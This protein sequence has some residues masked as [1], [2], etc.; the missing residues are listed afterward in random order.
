MHSDG[1][2]DHPKAD[3]P[4]GVVVFLVALPLCLGIAL[5]AGA[6]LISG[7][8]SG[9]IG[10]LVIGYLSNSA[11]SVSGPAASVSAVVLVAIQELGSFE[12]FLVALVL[13]GLIQLSLGLL[14]LGIIAEYIPNSIIKGLLAAIGI[15]LIKSQLLYAVGLDTGDGFSATATG[16]WA[17]LV[18]QL[19][20][21][22]SSITL[23][24]VLLTGFSLFI[25]LFWNKTP[26][27]NF[28]LLPPAL[29]VVILGVLLNLV[30]GW[31][32]PSLY[33]EGIHLV[34]IPSFEGV[35]S[36]VTFPD[37]S[38]MTNGTVWT[39]ALALA[40]IA[41]ISTLLNLEATDNIDP[42]RR[43]SSPNR[44]LIAQGI[45]NTLAGLLGGIAITSVIVR[46]SVNIEA[47]G[48]TKLSTIIHG[49]LLFLSVLFFGDIINLIPLSALA[50]ILLVVGY[51]LASVS[52]FKEFYQKG[53]NQFIPFVVTVVA[54]LFTDVLVGV[55]IGAVTSFFF[56]LRS[57]YHNP[58]FMVNGAIVNEEVI[59]ME[60]SNEV[61]FLNKAAIK[62]TLW[63]VPENS[64]V[65]IDA[66]F[67]NFIDQDV[68][69][70]LKDFRTGF[71][72]ERNVDV[73][74]I[75]LKDK[76]DI[77]E[78]MA[79]VGA[80]LQQAKE[81]SSPQQILDY[82]REGSERYSSGNL[83]SKRFRNQELND[84]LTAN[85]L[86]VVMNCI[87]LREPLNMLMNTAIG[88]IIP[89]RAAGN[90]LDAH[91]IHS[92]EVACR[93]QGAKLILLVGHSEN[94]IVM[95]A[96]HEYR[97][98]KQTALFNYL[99]DALEAGIVSPASLATKDPSEQANAITKFNIDHAV[100]Q[101]STQNSYLRE[102]QAKG[103]IGFAVAYF[104][105][106]DGRVTFTDL[107]LPCEI[108]AI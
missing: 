106:K 33:L 66:T 29:V 102:Q 90:T 62:N 36:F 67:S 35:S 42:Y 13:A 83:T 103:D 69:D 3:I 32:I 43:I 78:E 44:E 40:I 75:G 61:S 95:E 65:I 26:L 93:V 104:D 100:R 91:L 54:I 6:P 15:I 86:A 94:K 38:V 23:G 11:T 68:I 12:Y 64:K 16:W 77:G 34:S 48:R 97:M 21:F 49:L 17:V 80:S 8:V 51:K 55:L 2:F 107:Y 105:R 20:F 22:L 46:S 84:F 99:S 92:A 18:E 63:N 56:L 4:A 28:K 72:I 41:S 1:I 39:T 10:G 74:I 58:F 24:A 47:G 82:L 81:K 108:P 45:G 19:L 25:L 76:Y 53:W 87:D 71:A 88:D 30:F 60:L 70:I 101:L 57:N 5:A 73:S 27:R 37:F 79:L 14:K 59:K 7:L 98:G 89:I 50:A 85:P 52:L 9:V 31:A 96:I